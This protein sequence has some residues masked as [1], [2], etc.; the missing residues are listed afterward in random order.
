MFQNYFT[1]SGSIS[2]STNTNDCSLIKPLQPV[3]EKAFT[4]EEMLE[5][6]LLMQ[7]TYPNCNIQVLRLYNHSVAIAFNESVKLASKQS[8]YGHCSKVFIGNTLRE[9]SYFAQCTIFKTDSNGCCT[10]LRPWI[11]NCSSY[12]I[13]SC[14]PWYGYP[15]EV[16]SA[17]TNVGKNSLCISSGHWS[18]DTYCIHENLRISCMITSLKGTKDSIHSFKRIKPK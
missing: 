6:E 4:N 17:V 18:N 15:T 3:L 9:I 5:V 10:S 16:W 8:R 11:V 2:E 14:K 7:S 13:H 12:M 1:A